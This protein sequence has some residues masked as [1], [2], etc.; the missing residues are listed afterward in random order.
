MTSRPA[1]QQAR[2]AKTRLKLLD[3]AATVVRRDGISAM[4]LARVAE[5]A[6]VS[7]GGLLHHFG[8]KDELVT[9]LLDQTLADASSGLDDLTGGDERGAFAKAY[10]E[11]VR[12]PDEHQAD[13]ATAVFAAAAA[14]DGE[15]GP[16]ADVFAAW[17]HRLMHEDG[18]DPALGLLARIVGDG[19]WLIDLFGLG[20][21]SEDERAAVI[22]LVARL[23]DDPLD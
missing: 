15:L 7:K 19:L 23:L 2:A 11:Y 16:A 22:D 13:A 20:R 1:P 14:G 5:E 8:S 17:Q 6:G 12:R 4:T 3:A 10:L 9:G 21:P 18:L